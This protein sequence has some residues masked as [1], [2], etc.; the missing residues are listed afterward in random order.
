M[1]RLIGKIL[2]LGIKTDHDGKRIG[3]SPI[4][5]RIFFIAGSLWGVHKVKIRP[6]YAAKIRII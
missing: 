3:F 4:R 6:K 5:E 2:G 1:L